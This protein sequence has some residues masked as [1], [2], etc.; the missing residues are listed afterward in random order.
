[1]RAH[2]VCVTDEWY[3]CYNRGVDKRIV[4]LDYADYDRFLTLLYVC[5]SIQNIRISDARSH[6]LYDFLNRETLQRG[7]R[8]VHIGAY[9]LMP[10]HIHLALK[11]VHDNG[12]PR[13]MQKVFTAYTMYF[14]LKYE[15]T[16]SLFSGT[17]KSKHIA[18]DFYLK[19]LLSYIILNPIDLYESKEKEQGMNLSE[20]KRFITTYPFSSAPDFF[21]LLRPE[22]KIL[23]EDVASYFDAIPTIDELLQSSNKYTELS[24][25]SEV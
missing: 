2:G 7:S 19:H 9:A 10:N 15:R 6:E 4:F 11:Q 16:G 17:Y 20:I 12:I 5:N 14:N 8:L 21:G 13:F 23:D 22:K 3:H 24:E 1:M 18:D 25:R